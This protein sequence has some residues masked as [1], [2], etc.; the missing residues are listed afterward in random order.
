VKLTTHLQLVPWPR[1]LTLY[2]HS[3]PY[4]F[5]QELYLHLLPKCAAEHERSRTF[6]VC[7]F[8]YRGV[9]LA[10]F[11]RKIIRIYIRPYC[12]RQECQLLHV[13]VFGELFVAEFRVQTCEATRMASISR[14]TL[15]SFN[16]EVGDMPPRH[17]N[18]SL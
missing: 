15:I 6:P 8:E 13:G 4:V 1:M 14:L 12:L 18:L 3:S 9:A 11:K 7:F 10:F 2:L 16:T 5:T 17:V